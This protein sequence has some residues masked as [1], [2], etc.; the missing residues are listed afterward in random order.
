MGADIR[1]EGHHAVVRG[2][3]HL[4]GAT[5]RAP[6]IRAGVALVLAGL[7]ADGET[8]VGG[9]H[10]IARGYADLAGSLRSLGA[11]VTAR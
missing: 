2:V 6:D 11:T 10:H 5:V 1:T 4:S 9:A 8:V 3:D 7:V